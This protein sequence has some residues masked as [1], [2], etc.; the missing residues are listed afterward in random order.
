M[1]ILKI[2]LIITWL[3]G[4]L[5]GIY[6]GN[7]WNEVKGNDTFSPNFIIPLFILLFP[8]ILPIFLISTI[9]ERYDN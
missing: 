2:Y 5:I 9:F 4:I 8:V 6:S 1:L 7:H 3:I